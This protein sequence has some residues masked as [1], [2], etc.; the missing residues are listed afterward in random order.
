MK[1]CT[2]CGSVRILR[3]IPL[4]VVDGEHLHDLC[5]IQEITMFLF[6]VTNCSPRRTAQMPFFLL[7]ST[8]FN[9]VI[10][11]FKDQKGS[12]NVF[13][14]RQLRRQIRATPNPSASSVVLSQRSRSLKAGG[15]CLS[16]ESLSFPPAKKQQRP[17]CAHQRGEGEASG[18]RRATNSETLLRARAWLACSGRSV[19]QGKQHCRSAGGEASARSSP[20]LFRVA[21]RAKALRGPGS[22]E[23]GQTWPCPALGLLRSTFRPESGKRGLS[24]GTRTAR[25]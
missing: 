13:S 11:C 16:S 9:K 4:N 15:F 24:V 12:R 1:Y 21:K 20:R 25:R 2:V 23:P 8:S 19:S 6:S 3:H 17:N 22:F 14:S 5:S 10:S 7:L 18:I